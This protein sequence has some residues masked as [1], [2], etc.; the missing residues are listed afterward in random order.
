MVVSEDQSLDEV[1]IAAMRGESYRVTPEPTT[2]ADGYA[3]DDGESFTLQINPVSA[4]G[5]VHIEVEV[6]TLPN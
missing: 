1:T 4:G 2:G 6:D 3:L 5:T